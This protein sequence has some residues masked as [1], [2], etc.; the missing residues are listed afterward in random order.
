MAKQT[1]TYFIASIS[2]WAGDTWSLEPGTEASR[3]AAEARLK[4]LRD[5]DFDTN[6]KQSRKFRIMTLSEVKKAF[7]VDWYT[8]VRQTVSA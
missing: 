4:A 7:G 6:I 1:P 2:Y 3:P 8:R 5:A